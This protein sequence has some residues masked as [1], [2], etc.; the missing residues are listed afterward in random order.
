MLLS[1]LGKKKDRLEHTSH[2]NRV[3]ISKWILG[4]S[5]VEAE[6]LDCLP[7]VLNVRDDLET[8]LRALIL[9]GEF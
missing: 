7:D 5:I 8:P 4:I 3:Q 1:Q 6:L 2:L 9:E